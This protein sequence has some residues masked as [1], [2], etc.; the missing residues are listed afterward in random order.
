MCLI[1]STVCPFLHHHKEI[2]FCHNYGFQASSELEKHA[3]PHPHSR[4][5][6]EEQPRKDIQ[7]M[8]VQDNVM[9]TCPGKKKPAL[10]SHKRHTIIYTRCQERM[11]LS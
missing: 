8:E 1:G 6:A 11:A 4:R 3:Q 5:V 7:T 9:G 10:F 2:A